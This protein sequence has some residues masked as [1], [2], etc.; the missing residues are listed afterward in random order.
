MDA[1]AVINELLY[2]DL[3]PAGVHKKLTETDCPKQQ[4]EFLHASLL[5]TCTNKALM[6]ACDIISSVQG[7]PKMSALG[8]DMQ[9]RQESGVC[10]CVCAYACACVCVCASAFVW[11]WPTFVLTFQSF[12]Q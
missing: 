5:R 4:N 1:N 11:V 8:E 12:L 3:I 10:V 9:R 6:T 2:K 7:N